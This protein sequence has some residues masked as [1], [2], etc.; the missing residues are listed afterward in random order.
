M[1]RNRRACLGLGEKEV[2]PKL[3]PSLCHSDVSLVCGGTQK[4][5]L[6][7][8]GVEA[9]DLDFLDGTTL[10]VIFLLTALD[11][12]TLESTAD[13]SWFKEHS[14]LSHGVALSPISE[15]KTRL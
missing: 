15:P 2:F 6:E 11:P 3:P 13:L 14:V 4:Q 8:K 7:P 5:G 1:E 10:E 9:S 12:E